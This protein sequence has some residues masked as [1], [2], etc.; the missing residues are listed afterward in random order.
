MILTIDKHYFINLQKGIGVKWNVTTTV[1]KK[2][3]QRNTQE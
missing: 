3:P 2:D 1:L